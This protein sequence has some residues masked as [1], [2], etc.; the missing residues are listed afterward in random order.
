MIHLSILES[1]SFSNVDTPFLNYFKKEVSDYSNLP[2]KDSKKRKTILASN[3]QKAFN[4]TLMLWHADRSFPS[5]FFKEAL[6]EYDKSIE[7]IK[8]A[9]E[10]PLS[11]RE[12]I[13]AT[14]YFDISFHGG[15]IYREPPAS[16][17]N[18]LSFIYRSELDRSP[19]IQDHIRELANKPLKSESEYL[20]FTGADYLRKLYV[21]MFDDIQL[22]NKENDQ[23]KKY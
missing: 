2:P 20:P 21:R 16:L 23:I 15:N 11:T 10:N 1:E 18:F 13:S 22:N 5:H 17:A 6:K 12:A 19:F 14:P 8:R 4:V 7:N 9:R 3:V